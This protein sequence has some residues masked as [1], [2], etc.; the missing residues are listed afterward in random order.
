MV[1]AFKEYSG[2]DVYFE[3]VLYAN[4]W[5]ESHFDPFDITPDDSGSGYSVGIC[6]IH[7]RVSALYGC[8]P[9]DFFDPVLSIEVG[10]RHLR[11]VGSVQAYNAGR[12]GSRKGI[13]CI[14]GRRVLKFLKKIPWSR[15]DSNG[16]PD[17]RFYGKWFDKSNCRPVKKIRRKGH[18]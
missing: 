2:G 9:L 6:Q 14:H 16:N 5:A 4:T 17:M 12:R 7:R 15:K 3:T 1:D 10:S 13:G 8:E 18:G 11:E